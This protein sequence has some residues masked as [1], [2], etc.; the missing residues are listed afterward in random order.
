MK[1]IISSALIIAAALFC[2]VPA[3]AYVVQG[4]SFDG[5]DVGSLD[6]LLGQ[7]KYSGNSNPTSEA[8]WVNSIL[9]PDTT[10]VTKTESVTY[11][12][13]ETANVFAFQLQ[14]DPGY[15]L[16]KNAKWWAVFENNA[17]SNW[18]VVNFSLLDS[19]FKLPD[20]EK[21]E[22]SHV[23][24]FGSYVSVPEPSA[25]LLLGLGLFG[26]G[27]ARRRTKQV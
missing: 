1:K 15:F 12:S 18:G 2:A 27:A 11:Y 24:E 3:S 17:N 25:L 8:N 9:N 21:M 4:G 16:I 13:T 7:V 10:Y 19:G 5:T 14:S 23:T 20:L 6:T 26:L 22:I